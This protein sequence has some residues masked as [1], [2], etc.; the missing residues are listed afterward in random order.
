MKRRRVYFAAAARDQVQA[1]KAWW[2]ENSRPIE[3]LADEIEQATAFLSRLPGAGSAYPGAGIPDLRRL[4]LR[5]ISC[6]LYYTF[7]DDAVMIRAFWH[8]RR[9]RGP[10]LAD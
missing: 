2:V 5:R 1:A 3:I 7:T 10:I 4:Y 8:A 9:G 6:H